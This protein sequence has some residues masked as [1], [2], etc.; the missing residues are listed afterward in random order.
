M[1]NLLHNAII[2]STSCFIG[3]YFLHYDWQPCVAGW[4]ASVAI[5]TYMDRRR[6][7]QE[8]QEKTHE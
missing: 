1:N 2:A 3:A 6:A 4:F 8:K 7:K 5:L